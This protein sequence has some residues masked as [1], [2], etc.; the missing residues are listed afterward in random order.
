MIHAIYLVQHRL[1]LKLAL[2]QQFKGL[3]LLQE[4]A[5]HL[6]HH[7]QKAGSRI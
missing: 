2:L 6:L 5:Q 1:Q 3:H 4:Q 7:F